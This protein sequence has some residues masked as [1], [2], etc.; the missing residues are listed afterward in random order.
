MLSGVDLL[1]DVLFDPATSNARVGLKFQPKIKPQPRMGVSKAAALARS[2]MMGR[3]DTAC[4]VSKKPTKNDELRQSH[5]PGAQ[6]SDVTIPDESGEWHSSFKKSLGEHGDKFLTSMA[7]RSEETSSAPAHGSTGS[8]S[9]PTCD[10]A[11]SQTC[12]YYHSTQD[13]VTFSEAAVLMNLMEL[14]YEVFFDFETC[15]ATIVSGQRAGKFQPKPILIKEKEKPRTNIAQAEVQYALASQAD[16]LVSFDRDA[17]NTNHAEATHS[18]GTIL[19]DMHSEDNL[20][21]RGENQILLG[22][23]KDLLEPVR[24]L[25]VRHCQCS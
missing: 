8:S 4:P 5:A 15:E 19:G 2:N 22:G 24:G 10:I 1:G 18:D 23:A 13:P 9:F 20:A 16:H 25:K 21:M 11:H 17:E 7:T 6:Q 14:G 12:S 3:T